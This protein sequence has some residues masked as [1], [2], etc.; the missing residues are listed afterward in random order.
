[1]LVGARV[2]YNGTYAP[3][4]SPRVAVVAPLGHGLYSK[5]QLSSAFV[6]PAFLYRTGNSLSDYQ[7][8]PDIKPQSVRTAEAMVGFKND[9]MRA[10]LSGY[11]NDVTQF[12]TFD[13]A[14]TARTG[15]FKFANEGDVRVVGLEGTSTIRFLE[16]KLLVDLQGTLAKPLPSTTAQFLVDGQLGGATKYPEL[17]GRAVVSAS[18]LHRLHVTVDGTIT[19]RVKQTI[20][21]EVQFEGIVGTDGRPYSSA[22]AGSYDTSE[23]SFDGLAW[24]NLGDHWKVGVHGSNLLDHQYYRPGSV[25]VPYRAE[26]RRLTGS[27]TWTH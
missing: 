20:A 11:Y 13:Q 26:G 14:L 8:N 5:V 19:S 18:P 27:V 17:I 16:G 12:I 15:Q 4:F 25:L 10:E 9:S 24:Y 1:V 7:G 23:L 22:P 3:Q 2:D 21:R 6:Y